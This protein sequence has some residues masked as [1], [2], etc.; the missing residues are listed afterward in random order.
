MS[1]IYFLTELELNFEN[2]G[3]FLSSEIYIH[4]NETT[5]KESISPKIDF[6]I[7]KTIK[8]IGEIETFESTIFDLLKINID[9]RVILPTVKGFLSYPIFFQHLN[10]PYVYEHIHDTPLL[11]GIHQDIVYQYIDSYIEDMNVFFQINQKPTIIF[12]AS[13]TGDGIIGEINKIV[14]DAFYVQKNLFKHINIYRISDYKFFNFNPKIWE[15]NL[16]EGFKLLNIFPLDKVIVFKEVE[17][18]N[19]APDY[20]VEFEPG[21]YQNIGGVFVPFKIE[22]TSEFIV[23]GMSKAIHFNLVLDFVIEESIY[24]EYSLNQTLDYVGGMFVGPIKVAKIATDKDIGYN[25]TIVDIE[26][27]PIPLLNVSKTK[28]SFVFIKSEIWPLAF[29]NGW[30]NIGPT[31]QEFDFKIISPEPVKLIEGFATPLLEMFVKNEKIYTDITD[32]NIL[33]VKFVAHPDIV[34]TKEGVYRTISFD[35]AIKFDRSEY[36]YYNFDVDF[37]SEWHSYPFSFEKLDYDV[38][39]FEDSKFYGMSIPH[40]WLLEENKFYASVELIDDSIIVENSISKLTMYNNNGNIAG[41][42]S[43]A[44]KI[45]FISDI[46]PY[47]Y[48]FLSLEYI[49][50]AYILYTELTGDFIWTDETLTEA[51]NFMKSDRIKNAT[52]YC[53]QNNIYPY[54][55]YRLISLNSNSF[56]NEYLNI[57]KDNGFYYDDIFV[58]LDVSSVSQVNKVNRYSKVG[59]YSIKNSKM[60]SGVYVDNLWKIENCKQLK[61][62]S[63]KGVGGISNSLIKYGIEN[64]KAVDIIIGKTITIGDPEIVPIG[65][66][67]WKSPLYEGTFN[68]DIKENI[69]PLF[70]MDFQESNIGGYDWWT[71]FSCDSYIDISANPIEIDFRFANYNVGG[72]VYGPESFSFNTPT[73]IKQ[74]ILALTTYHVNVVKNNIG[75]IISNVPITIKLNQGIKNV[76]GHIDKYST[77]WLQTFIPEAGEASELAISVYDIVA[78]ENTWEINFPIVYRYVDNTLPGEN[79]PIPKKQDVVM[80]HIQTRKLEASYPTV[81]KPKIQETQLCQAP[82]KLLDYSGFDYALE[83]DD[84]LLIGNNVYEVKKGLFGG[85]L[86][87]KTSMFVSNRYA[88]DLGVFNNELIDMIQG[89]VDEPEDDNYTIDKFTLTADDFGGNISKESLESLNSQI[90]NV[91]G[92]IEK[93]QKIDNQTVEEFMASH[94]EYKEEMKRYLDDLRTPADSYVWDNNPARR[95]IDG[96][97]F[98]KTQM[99]QKINIEIRQENVQSD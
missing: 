48:V 11:F 10:N 58:F 72:L 77:V 18:I 65:T 39:L 28:T 81:S 15:F 55:V 73:T 54:G 50:Y 44:D 38:L 2:V 97:L 62:I 17:P 57:N 90:G 16:I 9:Y 40:Y 78:T 14:K 6:S 51:V 34:T 89:L 46:L 41:K 84:K 83:S 91:S 75:G 19:W 29:F 37:L 27:P 21:E 24:G 99:E 96:K 49:K 66:L 87:E 43:W 61:I 52:S 3:G 22:W 88:S 20:T 1:F 47:I 60:L 69:Y 31:I 94:P 71:T 12:N 25:Y 59:I 33:F 98:K 95:P 42:Y 68:G 7:E 30:K 53:Q 70:T 64:Y 4:F 82:Y 93:A 45:E 5:I 8:N 63:E 32:N 92:G 67:P 35:K 76:G 80:P 26:C 56:T 36:P 23:E 79:K 13:L 86:T 85:S 74:S